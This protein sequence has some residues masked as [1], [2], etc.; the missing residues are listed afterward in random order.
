MKKVFQLFLMVIVAIS[1]TFTACKKDEDGGDPS[2]AKEGTISAKI[3]GASFNSEPITS[4]ANL[5]TSAS[6]LTIQGNT[7]G[8]SSKALVMAIVGYDGVGTYEIGGDNLIFVNASY[9]EIE[10]NMNNPMDSKTKIWQ[11]PY[12]GGDV[13]G[14]IQ[15]TEQSDNNIKGKFNFKAK[16]TTDGSIKNISD[17][18]FNLKLSKF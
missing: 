9:T 4:A 5:V 3:D 14:Q 1:L 17:G 13:V 2:K 8:T 15:I 16:S 18:V 6:T 11:A 10:V 12:E 7:A